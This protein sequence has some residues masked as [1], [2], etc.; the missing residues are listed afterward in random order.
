MINNSNNFNHTN[1]FFKDVNRSSVL[2]RSKALYFKHGSVME[3]KPGIGSTFSHTMDKTLPVE[4]I[5]DNLSWAR[6]PF[7]KSGAMCGCL[8]L[9][10]SF[11]SCVK[12]YFYQMHQNKLSRNQ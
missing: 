10:S 11:S 1:K 7:L 2:G 9:Y 4:K 6:I 5:S 12:A 8:D 3:L